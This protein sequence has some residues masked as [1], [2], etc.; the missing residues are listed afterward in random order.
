MVGLE[1][2]INGTN[3]T[4]IDSHEELFCDLEHH[5]EIATFTIT[6]LVNV[7]GIVL[8]ILSTIFASLNNAIDPSL[9]G[10]FISFSF[11]N[12]T[13]TLL[14]IFDTIM[15]ICFNH[16]KTKTGIFINIS[17]SLTMSHLMF[18]L[19]AEYLILT[20]VVRRSVKDFSGLLIIA[21]IISI[22]IGCTL[23]ITANVTGKV[24]FLTILLFDIL[25]MC[26][27]Y[28]SIIKKS[29]KRTKA[30]EKYEKRYLNLHHH[31]SRVKKR[32]W[33][34]KYYA[35]ILVSYVICASPWLL[36]QVYEK[37]SIGGSS[38]QIESISLIIYTMNFYFPSVIIIN[39]WMKKYRA[40]KRTRKLYAFAKRP[41]ALGKK[42]Y[43]KRRICEPEENINCLDLD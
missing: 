14:L 27:G 5:H 6:L 33:K 26:I 39:L 40:K 43:E 18:L 11:A 29:Q 24:V 23:V 41:K 2:T 20:S 15:T 42:K 16:S 21:W 38:I 35:I 36:E 9:R 4:S 34:Q 19:L 17:I 30:L 7:I 25:G 31:R 32:Y 3:T 13:G 8:T 10:I 37:V 12:F 22:C 1:L 28:A